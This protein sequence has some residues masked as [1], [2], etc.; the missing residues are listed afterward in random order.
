M[1]RRIPPPPVESRVRAA[2]LQRG[3]SQQDLAARVGLT[4]Q[5]ISAIESGQYIPNT[6]VALRLAQALGCRVEDLFVLPA[7]APAPAVR[8]VQT[9]PPDTR[10]LALVNVRGQWI[11]YPLTADWGLVEGFAGADG[12]LP[13]PDAPPLF[14]T[15]PDRLERTALVLGCDPS[16]GLV[17]AHLARRSGEA[18]LLWLSAG[19][20]AALAAL[21]RGEAHLAGTH[22]AD[23]ATGE[24]NLPQARQALARTGGLVI[25]F[26]T[27]E[28]GLVVA[29]GNP[30]GLRSLADLARP[31]VRIVNRE[32]GSGA[33]AL[34]D[35]L[36]ARAGIPPTA[37]A[38]Y[39]RTVTSHLAVARAV[40]SGGADAGI[41]LRATAR[42]LGLDFVPLDEA[43]FDL[44]VPRDL[45]DHPAVAL[46]LDLLQSPALRAEL[47]ALPGYDVTHLGT[48]RADLPAS[49]A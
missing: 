26:A 48:V 33:R 14:L 40:A 49:P 46:L 16:L 30:K 28:L 4:R 27:W 19:S 6:V 1:G 45:L 20:T 34:L 21:A 3:L 47:A 18:R 5:A 32:P 41:A 23:P 39:D 7:P 29:P 44:V 8:L 25:A 13:T 35:H 17:S 31:G 24:Y 12:L 9:P 2:R 36:L 10:R 43:R 38:G 42:L 11:G 22:L 37:I 15:A